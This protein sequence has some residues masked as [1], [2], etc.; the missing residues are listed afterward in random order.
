MN[1]IYIQ[2]Q[3]RENTYLLDVMSLHAYVNPYEVPAVGARLIME[4]DGCEI[5]LGVFDT[6]SDVVREIYR[7]CTFKPTED[8]N[9]HHV[10]GYSNSAGGAFEW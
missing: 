3:D 7:I 4:S 6:L 9:T 8:C 1:K 2:D 10:S 5:M